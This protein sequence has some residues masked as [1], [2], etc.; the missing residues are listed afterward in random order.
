MAADGNDW[1]EDVAGGLLNAV[2]LF[3]E[4]PQRGAGKR[5]MLIHAA[6]APPHGEKYGAFGD[7]HSHLPSRGGAEDPATHVAAL[8]EMG[9]NYVF[10]RMD[11]TTE[12]MEQEFAGLYAAAE[13]APLFAISDLVDAS[14]RTLAQRTSGLS[15]GAR[16]AAAPQAPPQAAPQ[17][18]SFVFPAAPA[19][20]PAFGG[21]SASAAPAAAAWAPAAAP[22][23]AFGGFSAPAAAAPAPAAAAWAPAAAVPGQ[24][25]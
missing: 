21:F 8:A 14:G 25:T 17:A 7:R 1:H 23:P 9:V 11:E 20:Q 10:I 5:L 15:K 22:Q 13:K 19:P 24:T 12:R 3:Q 16:V 6:D 2:R 4:L 18:F